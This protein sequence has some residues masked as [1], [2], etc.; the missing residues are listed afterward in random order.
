MENRA[1][2]RGFELFKQHTTGKQVIKNYFNET[3]L[4]YWRPPEEGVVNILD[5]GCA[6]GIVTSYLLNSLELPKNRIQLTLVEPIKEELDEALKL[7]NIYQ[8]QY[9]NMTY[10]EYI[11]HAE[12]QQKHH[13]I[14]NSHSIYYTG[15]DSLPVMYSSLENFGA[16][17]MV[18]SGKESFFKSIADVFP[19]AQETNGETVYENMKPLPTNNLIYDKKD[20]SLTIDYCLDHQNNITEQ[21]KDLASFLLLKEYDEYNKAEKEAIVKLFNCSPTVRYLSSTNDFIWAIN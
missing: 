5:I 8:P 18:V 3:V 7:L 12:N 20:I 21:G 2:P 19:H 17:L 16:L 15:L 13:L 10:A 6:Q 9:F 1:Y 4:K 14:L 11:N